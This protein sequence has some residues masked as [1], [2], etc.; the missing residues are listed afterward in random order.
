MAFFGGKKKKTETPTQQPR[1]VQEPELKPTA[2]P[3]LERINWLGLKV[4]DVLGESLFLEEKLHLKHRDEGNSSIGHHVVYDCETLQ[5]ELVEGGQT[6]VS[7]AK[8]RQGN[9]DVPLIA[10]FAVDKIEQIAKQLNEAELLTTQIFDQGW[11]ASLLFFD[12]ERNLWQV[13]ETRNAPPVG[14][15]HLQRIGA[16][17]LAVEDLSAQVAFYREVLGL[18]LSDLGNRPRPITVEAE[19][20]HTDEMGEDTLE[21]L[22][23]LPKPIF[24][25]DAHNDEILGDGA[26]F[27]RQ[28]VRLVLTPGGRKREGGHEK[29]WGRDTSFMLGFQTNNLTGMAEKLRQAGV[30]VSHPFYA[31]H[32]FSRHQQAFRFTDPEGNVCQV[33]G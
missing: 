33:S 12:A 19:R 3:H 15:S 9:P 22:G 10:S 11:V 24:C 8:P 21:Q 31:V 27:F 20:Q 14:L 13:N 30:K 1:M 4:F 32:S 26:T 7:R 18:P 25:A 17:W 6:W 16:L 2:E 5:L 29:H 28:G 23:P